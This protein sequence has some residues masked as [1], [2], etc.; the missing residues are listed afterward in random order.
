MED[1]RRHLLCYEADTTVRG[2][3][4]FVVTEIEFSFLYV[5]FDLCP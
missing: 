1:T 3:D 5:F 4:F 2:K